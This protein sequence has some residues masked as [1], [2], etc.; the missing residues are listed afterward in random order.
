MKVIHVPFCFRP[1][2]V[3]GTEVYVEALAGEQRRRG[4]DV[5]VAAPARE[6]SHHFEDGLSVYRFAVAG[7]G[8]SLRSLYGGGDRTATRD[9]ERIL[10]EERPE[11]VHLHAFTSGV[12]PRLARDVKQRGLG[13]VFTY[14]TPTVSCARGT[15]LRWGRSVCDGQLRVHTCARCTLHGLGVS[16]PAATLV[17][18]VP[19]RLGSV[20]DRL[21]LAGGLWTGLR[22]TE[23]LKLQQ[24]AFRSFTGSTDRIV[25]L[26]QWA[27]DLLTRNKVPTEKISLSRHGLTRL[28]STPARLPRAAGRTRVAFVGRLDPTKGVDVLI[29]AVRSA[30]S[31]NLELDI[32]GLVQGESSG[33]YVQHVRSLADGDTRI[34]FCAPVPS[35]TVP[36]LL[37]EYDA[38]AVP[39]CWLET[40]PLV[41]LE[42]FA[43]GIP[44]LGSRLGGIAELIRHD[45]DG[46]LVE[47]GSVVNWTAT[48][49]R[50]VAEAGLLGRLRTGVRPPRTMEV[51]ADDMLMVYRAAV[52]SPR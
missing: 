35:H 43:A 40:G 38:L 16:A 27:R 46:L 48:L 31:L 14:H 36:S 28:G 1:D 37:A 51:V 50:V 3:G 23:L 2:V 49:S 20:L 44:V 6:S 26:C 29:R 19:P 10:D 32:Y 15:L 42:A 4:M 47:S 13:L 9:F 33:D 34:R 17:G 7:D 8:Q 12:S 25:V 45:V 52:A 5:V 24:A 30:P 22:M 39:S 18:S 21:G 11:I 41:V